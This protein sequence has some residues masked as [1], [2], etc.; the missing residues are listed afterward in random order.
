MD[1][2]FLSGLGADKRAFSQIT[3]PPEFKVHHIEWI[4]PLKEE[5]LKDYAKRLAVV[6]DDSKPFALVGLS[7]G[8]MM[9]VE[10]A[11][12]LHSVKT[13]L[14]SSVATSSQLPPHH[15]QIS[16]F[17]LYKLLPYRLFKKP[18]FINYWLFGAK[19]KKEKEMLRQI[20]ND[21]DFEFLKWAIGRLVS[22]KNKVKPENLFHIHGSADM[23][24]PIIFV[25]PDVVIKNG[26]HLMIHK[27]AAEISVILAEQLNKLIGK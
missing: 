6:I 17:K 4:K 14:I 7:F 23:I 15:R 26:G 24:F 18:G 3:I 2:Y 19:T 25:K 27:K 10:I 21:T 20:L 13:I 9:A 12:F 1:V 11:Q 8:G 16:H 5:S 22:W